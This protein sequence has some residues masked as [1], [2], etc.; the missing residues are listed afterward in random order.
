MQFIH[1][2]EGWQVS[3]MKI[4]IASDSY[5]G[6]LDSESV[7]ASIRKG[8]LRVFPDAE[9]KSIPIGDGG[10]GTVQALVNAMGGDYLY[11]EVHTPYGEIVKA[12][13]GLLKNGSAVIE[14]A[15][16]SG[17]A[18]L[19][20]GEKDVMKASSYGLGELIRSALDRGCRRIYIGIGGSATNDGGVGMS[21]ALGVSFKDAKVSEVGTGAR[22]LGE[23]EQIDLSGL[24]PRIRES[25]ITVICDVT[26]PLCGPKGAS[27][28]YGPQKGASS[29]QIVELDRNLSHFADITEKTIGKDLRNESGAGA[30]GGTG[31]ALMSFLN[32]KLLPGIQAIM[33][34][35]NFDEKLQW[36]DLVITGEGKIDGQSVCGKV[37]DGIASRAA[38]YNK[39]V[40]AIAG[41]LD[42]NLVDVYNAGV[43]S[44]E[45]SVCRPMD[46]DEAM[47]DAAD[48]VTDAA[49]R[50]L[51]TFRTGMKM[52]AY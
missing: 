7:A 42:K 37:I 47:R 11:E 52:G 18:L 5:K 33:N 13:Y 30:A 32:A 19:H 43:S 10:E 49:E 15:E 21:Q 50:V 2:Q 25:E 17:L 51:R 23:I 8:V 9:I 35:T 45:A 41:S 46:L 4:L 24:D 20:E 1:K 34:A 6:S 12:K 22:V 14:M 48:M 27:Y 39:P 3:G 44:M 29:S 16:S 36:A 28:V 31:F 26:N 38:K 40:I